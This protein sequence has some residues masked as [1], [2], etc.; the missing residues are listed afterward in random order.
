MGIQGRGSV[1]ENVIT[2]WDY[3]DNPQQD[4]ALQVEAKL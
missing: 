1:V 3:L 4:L 2:T